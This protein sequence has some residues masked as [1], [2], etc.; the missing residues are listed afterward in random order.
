MIVKCLNYVLCDTPRNTI[1]SNLIAT[2]ET[3]MGANAHFKYLNV[4]VISIYLPLDIY[5]TLEQ[6]IVAL[7]LNSS[8]NSYDMGQNFQFCYVQSVQTYKCSDFQ[9]CTVFTPDIP[10]AKTCIN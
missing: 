5:Y 6:N 9:S 3:V 10:C 8:L 4:K 2:Y 7:L 1:E